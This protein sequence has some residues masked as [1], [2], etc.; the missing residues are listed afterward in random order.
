MPAELR[1]F[2]PD[3]RGASK[4]DPEHVLRAAR[5]R[6]Q[7][8]RIAWGHANGLSPLDVLRQSVN[9]SRRA[10]GVAPHDYGY[11]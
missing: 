2:D 3:S 4:N 9:D 6:W 1:A 10:S 5:D 11:A 8:A 7:D